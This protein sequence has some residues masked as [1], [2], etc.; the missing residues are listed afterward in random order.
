VSSGAGHDRNRTQ[1]PALDRAGLPGFYV[2]VWNALWAP[3]RTPQNIIAK[4]NAAVVEALA[5]QG[6][7]ARLADLDQE[8]FPREQQ[9]PEALA[10]F[11]KGRDREMVADHRG[12]QHQGRMR[13]TPCF[14]LTSGFE[15]GMAR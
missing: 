10:A 1:D 9:T 13:Q 5:D 8:I 2:S 4:L 12:G 6:V 14:Q 3:K 15:I 7:R 11:P